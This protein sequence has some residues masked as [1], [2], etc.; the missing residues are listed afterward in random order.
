MAKTR[1]FTNLKLTLLKMQARRAP[2][3][4]RFDRMIAS[5]TGDTQA[6]EFNPPATIHSITK[7]YDL[8][9][10]MRASPKQKHN[11]HLQNKI[12]S[13]RPNRTN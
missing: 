2:S 3:L 6:P 4:P 5:T 12:R 8:V 1:P 9:H 13:S 10:K 7:A 11:D